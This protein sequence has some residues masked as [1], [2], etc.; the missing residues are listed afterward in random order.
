MLK[1][2]DNIIGIIIARN[3][4]E[5]QGLEMNY[6]SLFSVLFFSVGIIALVSG[7]FVLQN[8]PKAR[9]NRCFF[10]LNLSIHFWSFGLGM[11]NIAPDQAVCEIWRLYSAIGWGTAYAIL[12]HFILLLT[13]KTALL[14]KKLVLMLLYLPALLSVLAFAIPSPMNP[15]PYQLLR[16]E[17]G[18]VNVSIISEQTIWDWLFNI[19][20]IVYS[21]TGLILVLLWGRN[22]AERSIKMQARAIFISFSAALILASVTDVLL[23]NTFAKIP[24]MAPIVLMIPLVTLY[25]IMNRYGLLRSESYEKK[26]SYMRIFISVTVYIIAI[27]AQQN[28]SA[29][30][31]TPE[32]KGSGQA[33]L[34]IITQVQMLVSIYLVLRES[35]PGFIAS[36][37]LNAGS[38]AGSI[39]VMIRSSSAAPLPGTISYAGVLLIVF[40]IA[41]Y[42]K[43][44]AVQIKKISSQK[45][46]LMESEKKLYRMA[47][48]DS[49]T[50]LH[51]KEWLI[52]H[53]DQAVYEAKENAAVLGVI[54][55]DLDSFKAVNN[56]MGHSAGDDVLREMA[57]RLSDCLRETDAVARF[58]GDEF[59]IM[60][61]DVG[62]LEDLIGIT[63]RIMGV[64]ND[65]VTVKHLEYIITGSAGVA[66]YPSDGDDAEALIKNADIAMYLAKRK[67][68]NQCVYCTPE[69]KNETVKKMILTNSLYGA[70][71]RSELFL[72]YQPQVS[73]KTREI[74]GFEAL[75]RWKNEEY[76]IVSPDIFIPIAEQTGMSRP[77]GIWVFEP[78]CRQLK[79]FQNRYRKD[80]CMSINVSL[81]QLQDAGIVGDMQKILE[82]T[83]TT[84]ESVQVE[85]TES[86]A[87]NKDEF[88]LE[89]LQGIK[90]LGVALSIDDFGTGFS[91]FIRLKTFPIDLLKIDIELV[92]GISTG[93]QKDMSIIKSIIQ[94][95]NNLGISVLAE[96]V[97]TREQ[98]LFLKQQACDYIQGYYFYK[99]MPA[100]EVE[101]ILETRNL[102]ET[103]SFEQMGAASSV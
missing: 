41:S 26:A 47:Y 54:F 55:I 75:L 6:P 76:G 71:E 52:E 82:E 58:G 18:W 23:G 68:K 8:S 50:G 51:N 96:G 77:I 32:A 102:E 40:L 84:P 1:K 94:I 60:V 70:L 78:A 103:D 16:T 43:R 88:I 3:F 90:N 80:L 19:Y 53:L 10:V 74:I 28:L 97:E 17:F 100:K 95:A 46:S 91:S 93:S 61:S 27:Y 39:Y 73:T 79:E 9:V 92:R 81:E 12:L 42:K 57:S 87:F 5:K 34:G 20:Y 45:K 33:L 98:Y 4:T 44:T 67:G 64:F 31:A 62:H 7:I 89:Q 13:G 85:I 2:I 48:Y 37:L 38:L 59:L 65:S 72:H 21:V 22:A 30:S 86:V 11:A 99:P 25:Y 56:T 69:I 29:G 63:D 36:V 49:L 14:K 66:V 24:Q 83:K 35:R 15:E 101:K